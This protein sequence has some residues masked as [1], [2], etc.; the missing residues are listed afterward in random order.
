LL[1]DRM[2]RPIP[3]A[4]IQIS[5]QS[6]PSGATSPT[7]LPSYRAGAAPF[8]YWLLRIVRNEAIDHT[9][10][11]R[12]TAP[13]EP[14]AIEQLREARES[15]ERLQTLAWGSNDRLHL[16]MQQL[17][18]SQRQV[19]VLHYLAGLSAGEIGAITGH[20]ADAVR[21]LHR[22]ALRFLETRLSLD[23]AASSAPNTPPP[24]CSQAEQKGT[25]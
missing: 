14:E 19:L 3:V 9:R 12:R 17:P 16:L 15:E 18:R 11:N 4:G 20:R 8:E 22:R 2:E 1:G 25:K 10:R 7:A 13:H 6:A 23:R 24:R 5:D 21:Q